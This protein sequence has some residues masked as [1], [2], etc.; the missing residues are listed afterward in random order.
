ME[1]SGLNANTIL[2]YLAA[3]GVDIVLP[4]VEF[5]QWDS[6]EL[7]KIK[8]DLSEE[9]YAYLEELS[10]IAEEALS[11][12]QG[13]KLEDVYRWAQ[14]VAI[15]RI[16]PLAKKLE[17]ASTKKNLKTLRKAGF[18]LVTEGAPVIGAATAASGLSVGGMT[19]ALEAL[20]AMFSAA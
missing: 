20:R 16:A 13:E 14:N 12:L 2:L 1:H 5:A 18:R 8:E 4:S 3:A 17:V 7:K 11:A 19:L 9:R 10:S 15:F 6:D